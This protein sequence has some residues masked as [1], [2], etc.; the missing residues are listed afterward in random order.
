MGC[1]R[2]GREESEVPPEITYIDLFQVDGR[3]GESIVGEVERWR[4]RIYPDS[5]T[6]ADLDQPFSQWGCSAELLSQAA[7]L[8]EAEI[9]WT[10]AGEQ[11][12]GMWAT[13]PG[14]GHSAWSVFQKLMVRHTPRP[15][16]TPSP[17]SA[18]L[19]DPM[20]R[21]EIMPDRAFIS[22]VGDVPGEPAFLEDATEF[23]RD[24]WGILVTRVGSFEEVIDG[25]AKMRRSAT[26]L[27]IVSHASTGLIKLPLF[28]GF[29]TPALNEEVEAGGGRT[30]LL[31][32]D[33]VLSALAENEVALVETLLGYPVPP[34]M[35]VGGPGGGEKLADLVVR[36]V[37]QHVDN[38]S[39]LAPF[40][41]K[42]SGR[43]SGIVR[44]LVGRAVERSA[45]K[46]SDPS[47]PGI[48]DQLAA[49]DFILNENRDGSLRKR[50]AS[51]ANVS[52]EEVKQLEKAIGT[53][54]VVST[55]EAPD[56][57]N[58]QPGDL[59]SDE[60]KAVANSVKALKRRGRRRIGQ[61]IDR[62]RRK[63]QGSPRRIDIRGCNILS[64]STK[65]GEG[66]LRA[67]RQIFD[68]TEAAEISGAT[69][70]QFYPRIEVEAVSEQRLT[71]LK[72]D[73]APEISDTFDHWA[74][75]SG[76]IR[77]LG[78]LDKWQEVPFPL[79][80]IGALDKGV[81]VPILD[82]TG[83][84]VGDEG[85]AY[86]LALNNSLTNSVTQSAA[87]GLLTSMWVKQDRKTRP[88]AKIN[89]I[90]RR[91]KGGQPPRIAMLTDLIFHDPST[92]MRVY[93]QGDE[94][95]AMPG[96]K[97]LP[98]AVGHGTSRHEFKTP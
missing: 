21:P 93:F 47:R 5:I 4:V 78:G 68:P 38:G 29:V 95:F 35:E 25:V 44:E 96:I 33:R 84:I 72:L 8:S 22:T 90:L 40:R 28:K 9:R 77:L 67:V 54:V 66:L 79:R 32:P 82:R 58:F 15:K 59:E 11:W 60:T 87:K 14:P 46:K 55:T 10:E 24:E 83:V 86:M 89:S 94:L 18:V 2:C 69:M 64:A 76:W 57:V 16:P 20:G 85:Q 1:R 53:R 42:D 48:T 73:G 97:I 34:D 62:C 75:I 3:P 12:V 23:H 45:L 37:R 17:S 31:T 51:E 49:V 39:A 98:P 41:L 52:L 65:D 43:P 92:A 19:T 27:R 88:T 26:T 30:D 36:L 56:V 7:D 81:P 70:W 71:G 50:V 63:F 80:G 6:S 74:Q 61:A 13:L 91:W